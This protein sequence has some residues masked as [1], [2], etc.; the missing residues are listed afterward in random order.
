MPLKVRADSFLGRVVTA[1]QPAHYRAMRSEYERL[2]NLPSGFSITWDYDFVSLWCTNCPGDERP[3]DAFPGNPT[4]M[5]EIFEAM[6]IHAT[7]H[8]ERS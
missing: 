2:L 3:V 5:A 8:E 7:T 4:D 1:S 6:K